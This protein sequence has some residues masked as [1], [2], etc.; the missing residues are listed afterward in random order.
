MPIALNMLP[1]DAVAS[2]AE[3]LGV[4]TL[5]LVT[6]AL[7]ITN[8]SERKT[9]DGAEQA[10]RLTARSAE[11]G[12]KPAIAIL[13]MANQSDDSTQD[14]FA[15][16]LTQD[17]INAMGRFPELTVMSWNAVSQ[18]KGRA[19]GPAEIARALAVRY[20]VEGSVRRTGERVRV[21]ARLVDADGRVV[22]SSS[23]D[24]ALTDLFALLDKITTQIA[25][26]LAIRVTQ[27]EQ[28]RAS[29]K[30]TGSLEAY[31]Y[32]L[33]AKPAL[34]RPA[35]PD[36]AI[37][38]VMLRRAIDLDP[39]YA[40]AYSALAE[41]Y[42]TATSMGWAELPAKFLNRPEEFAN[43]ALRL[44]NSD[45]RARIILGR[46]HIFYQRYDKA[47]AEMDRAIA[48]NPSHAHAIAGRGNLRV[49]GANRRCNRRSRAGA[50][51]RS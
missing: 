49:V 39:N 8:R 31:D 16:G 2:T 33:R 21:N 28:Q 15:D 20:Q 6:G 13:P 44:D 34:Q 3:A 7:W 18:Y 10:D 47:S 41:T 26:A 17:I 32:V 40:A 27:L 11:T 29:A 48:V 42:F 9:I 43:Q 46:F 37:A 1:A 45:V 25:K 23:Q 22:W 35:R 24:E 5:V 36:I 12:V 51:D 4:L 19:A 38:R 50:A 14:Y 30:P